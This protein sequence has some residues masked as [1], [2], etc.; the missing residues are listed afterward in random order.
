M[1]R[2]VLVD[3][4]WYVANS[5]KGIDPLR[6]LRVIAETHDL[7]TCGVI[8]TEVGQGIKQPKALRRFL[9]AWDLMLFVNSSHSIWNQTLELSWKLNR[10]GII[11]PI[12]DIHIAACAQSIGGVIL[13]YDN[14]FQQIPGTQSTDR[15]F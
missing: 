12:Q 11:L 10:K 6:A 15:I 7:A 2:P 8:T 3:S 9:T 4:C 14:H 5:R 1:S 13:T